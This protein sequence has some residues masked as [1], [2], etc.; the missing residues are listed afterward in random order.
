MGGREIEIVPIS[1]NGCTQ[2]A[3]GFLTAHPARRGKRRLAGPLMFSKKAACL[4]REGGGPNTAP[5]NAGT[6]KKQGK[7]REK[8]RERGRGKNRD[9]RL[10]SC[11]LGISVLAVE[12]RTQWVKVGRISSEAVCST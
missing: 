1:A 10:C 12:E 9:I 2:I 6:R 7:K 11:R 5:G 3:E 8:E 4:Q